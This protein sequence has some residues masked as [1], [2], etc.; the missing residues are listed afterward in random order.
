MSRAFEGPRG[1]RCGPHFI[2]TRAV[3]KSRMA[4]WLKRALAGAEALLVLAFV[5][6][7]ILVN[8]IDVKRIAALAAAEVKDAT[9][10]ELK[11]GATST[12]GSSR[13]SRS[14]PRT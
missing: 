13:G 7:V 11:I 2:C 6:I 4:S 10:R 3:P 12:S 5:A 14:S 8:T 9:G 1:F